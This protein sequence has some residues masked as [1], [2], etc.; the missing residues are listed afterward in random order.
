MKKASDSIK[1]N[2][3]KNSTFHHFGRCWKWFFT[4]DGPFHV[5]ESLNF[6]RRTNWSYG[7]GCSADYRLETCEVAAFLLGYKAKA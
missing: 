1:M 4:L 5:P 2:W 6:F 3:Q 7:V